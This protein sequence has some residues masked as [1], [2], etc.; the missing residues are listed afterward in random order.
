MKDDYNVPLVIKVLR[1]VDRKKRIWKRKMHSDA[2]SYY[3]SYVANDRVSPLNEQL[4]HDVLSYNPKSVFEFGCG[5]GR[6][7]E[8]LKEKVANIMGIDISE[9]AIAIA[10]KKSLNVLLGDET[11]L[12]TI[13]NQDVVFTCSVLDHIKEIDG[14]IVELKRIANMAIVIAETNSEIGKF[15]YA[16]DY[17]SFGF[18]KTDY[19]FISN[20]AKREAIYNIWH[21]KIK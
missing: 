3:R 9:R 7:L 12:Q 11:K 19:V 21:F 10:S 5:V 4:I 6:N 2:K 1:F 8:L 20:Q 16:H 15:Y 18:V 17:E 13:K 14:I